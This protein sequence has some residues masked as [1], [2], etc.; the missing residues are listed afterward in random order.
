M[1][2]MT[3]F[4]YTDKRK[5]EKE[6][7]IKYSQTFPPT[8]SNSPALIQVRTTLAPAP[9][10]EQLHKYVSPLSSLY[11]VIAEL[12]FSDISRWLDSWLSLPPQ[13]TPAPY[14]VVTTRSAGPLSINIRMATRLSI[15]IRN[16][17]FSLA[18]RSLT[19]VYLLSTAMSPARTQLSRLV[20]PRPTALTAYLLVALG[21]L[22]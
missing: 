18:T 9:A 21:F 16:R 11:N 8:S 4:W 20:P 5:K 13:L 10:Q 2:G 6:P 12:S 19:L 15:S 7:P 22:C 14:A 3:F 1:K 17:A